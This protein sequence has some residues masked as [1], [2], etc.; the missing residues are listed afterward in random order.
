MER[1][2][3]TTGIALGMVL[4]LLAAACGAPYES[5]PLSGPSGEGISRCHS[6]AR[7]T[8][9]PPRTSTPITGGGR[10]PSIEC[11]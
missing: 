10:L 8:G 2:I 7:P 4:L 9:A 5:Q 3:R 1:I 6:D 11:A